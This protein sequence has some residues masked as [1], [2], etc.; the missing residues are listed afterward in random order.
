MTSGGL[1]AVAE[2]LLE[3]A[4]EER[5]VFLWIHYF[6][7]HFSYVDHEDLEIARDGSPLPRLLQTSTLNDRLAEFGE[8]SS[9]P[10]SELAYVEE[11][12]AEEIEHTDRW[13]GELLSRHLDRRGRRP[14]L[15]AVV[16]DH[17]EYFL[18]R[19]R[20]F[21]GRDVYEEL[22][23][24]PLILSGHGVVEGEERPETVSTRNLGRTLLIAAGLPTLG[25]P[26]ANLLSSD[27][28]PLRVFAE[29]NYAWGTDARKLA[30]YE[31]A[32][33]LIHRLDDDTYE[34]YDLSADPTE[35]RDLWGR[36]EFAA[37]ALR[38]REALE[39]FPP[40]R[41]GEGSTVTL[42]EETRER[43]RSLGYTY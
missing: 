25:F 6:D 37:T 40:V 28:R 23:H 14:R 41:A 22:V 19:G 2:S 39:A 1:T 38:L 11:V 7:P 32:M 36:P 42:D 8:A 15:V 3:G 4:D 21:H 26:G 13:I 9:F 35:G 18:E 29:G 17:G 33:K 5:P 12:Y 27:E 31:A 34:L 43:L 10:D 30:V 20:F 16:G 24:V